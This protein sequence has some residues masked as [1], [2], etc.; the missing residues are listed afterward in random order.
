MAPSPKAQSAALVDHACVCVMHCN[1]IHRRAATGHSPRSSPGFRQM[2]RQR[3]AARDSRAYHGHTGAPH[4]G[5]L[6]HHNT[7]GP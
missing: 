6:T 2:R 3:S 7:P 1:T 5:R 4:M